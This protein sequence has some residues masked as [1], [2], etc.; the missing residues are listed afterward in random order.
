MV[1]GGVTLVPP[2][3]FC[4]DP[5][6][7]TQRFALL[8]RCDVLSTDG[9]AA[10][11]LAV[12]TVSLSD[13]EAQTTLPSADQTAA[14]WGLSDV[15][16]T[17]TRDRSVIFRADGPTPSAAFHASQWRGTALVGG[18]VMGVALYGAAD[19][20]PIGA[21]GGSILSDLIAATK[22]AE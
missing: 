10:A 18:H 12:I 21:E 20:P 4:I 17:R 13:A 16:Q 3:G 14:A 15:R 6:A 8:A 11:P 1:R 19:R 2:F 22:T 5:A 9:L 7:V